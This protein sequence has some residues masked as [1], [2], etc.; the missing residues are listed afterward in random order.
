MIG[1]PTLKFGTVCTY[2][3]IFNEHCTFVCGDIDKQNELFD[4]IVL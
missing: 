4:Y 2:V 3:C 1:V